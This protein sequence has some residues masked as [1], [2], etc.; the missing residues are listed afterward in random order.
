MKMERDVIQL[1]GSGFS[2][3]EIATKLKIS[4]KA[5]IMIGRRVGIRFP[6][7]ELKA[8]RRTTK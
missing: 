4:P 5:V 2:T 6:P 8:A 3:E 1:A 7:P